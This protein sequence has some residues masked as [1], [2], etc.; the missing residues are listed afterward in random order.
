MKTRPKQRAEM[1]TC[2]SELQQFFNTKFKIKKKPAPSAACDKVKYVRVKAP[3]P[4]KVKQQLVMVH[5]G[6][7]YD[8][9]GKLVISARKL[10][11]IFH[12]RF[13]TVFRLL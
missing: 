2:L 10:S 11:E 13:T 7:S 6:S 9:S 5:Y 3:I 12:I 4:L 8:F 1:H